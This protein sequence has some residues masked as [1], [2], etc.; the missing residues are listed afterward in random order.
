MNNT[1][2]AQKSFNPKWLLLALTGFIAAFL[3]QWKNSV[4]QGGIAQTD[5]GEIVRVKV[6]NE[7]FKFFTSGKDVPVANAFLCDGDGNI[8]GYLEEIISSPEKTFVP[9]LCVSR[10]RIEKERFVNV[11]IPSL[12]NKGIP[13]ILMIENPFR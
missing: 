13:V 5:S 2:T 6:E 11:V 12:K 4:D 3:F 1:E 9:K 7:Q 10:E 8:L